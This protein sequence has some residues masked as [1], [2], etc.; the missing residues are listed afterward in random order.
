MLQGTNSQ[1][2]IHDIQFICDK[3]GINQTIL[4]QILGISRQTFTN[5][6][7][8]GVP[9]KKIPFVELLKT[10]DNLDEFYQFSEDHTEPNILRRACIEG[11]YSKHELAKLMGR[12]V[13]VVER[14]WFKKDEAL[15][16][17][18]VAVGKL[19]LKI[20]KLEKQAR[21]LQAVKNAF[22]S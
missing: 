15:N 17:E 3:H 8:L 21:D 5:W 19:L 13:G 20:A 12:P 16:K 2:A 9:R 11:G 6:K 14:A 1:R 10:I 18:I 7:R 4:G 22:N